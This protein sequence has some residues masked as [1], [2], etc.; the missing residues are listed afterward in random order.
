[1]TRV[2]I[3]VGLMIVL[4]IGLARIISDVRESLR[5]RDFARE[6]LG[7][8]AVFIDSMNNG[9]DDSETCYWLVHRSNRIESYLGSVGSVVYRPAFAEFMY[10]DYRILPNTL[11]ELRNGTAHP[12]QV[13]GCERVLVAYIGLA[14]DRLDLLRKHLRNPGSWLR[15][16]IQFLLL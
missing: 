5:R 6:Y 9:R 16:G 2:R 14:D 15:R 8:L 4:I 13:Q 10:P 7:K 11:S 3:L 1:M 12:V